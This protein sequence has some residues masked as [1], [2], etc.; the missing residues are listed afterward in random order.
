MSPCLPKHCPFHARHQTLRYEDRE[1]LCCSIASE[2]ER[3]VLNRVQILKA[4]RP[5]LVHSGRPRKYRY[6][7]MSLVKVRRGQ[8]DLCGEMAKLLRFRV[9]SAIRTWEMQASTI[10]RSAA[11]PMPFAVQEDTRRCLD[12]GHHSAA[13]QVLASVVKEVQVVGHHSH[14]VGLGRQACIAVMDLEDRQAHG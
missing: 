12:E 3:R 8:R 9:E 5:Q 7:R 14:W 4:P 2:A 11:Y 10:D 1:A 6:Y 13:A